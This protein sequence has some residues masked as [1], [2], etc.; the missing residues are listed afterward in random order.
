MDEVEQFIRTHV[1]GTN[2]V[3]LI[4]TMARYPS[5]PFFSMRGLV[6]AL[7]KEPL[8]DIPVKGEEFRTSLMTGRIYRIHPLKINN[9]R[10]EMRLGLTRFFGLARPDKYQPKVRKIGTRI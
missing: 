4:D 1:L 7:L 2:S 10:H 3:L 6:D 8:D 5:I 9:P